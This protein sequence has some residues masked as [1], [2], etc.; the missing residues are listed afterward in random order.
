MYPA[1]QFLPGGWAWPAALM[2]VASALAMARGEDWP[3]FRGPTGQGISSEKGLPM[4]WSATENIAWKTAIPGEGW[5]SPISNKGRVFVTSAGE[6]GASCR[7]ICLDRADGKVL[8][9]KEVHRQKPLRKETRNS[10]ATSTPAADGKR[11]YA[12][13]ADGAILAADYEGRVEW[14]NRDVHFYGQHGLGTSPLLYG[15]LLIVSFDG[16][17]ETGDKTIGWQKPWDKSFLLALDRDSGKERWRVKRGLSR[18]AH[19]TPTILRVDGRDQ[20]IS[21]AGDVIQGFDPA[22]GRR[23]WSV[24][25]EGEGVVPS[26]VCGAGLVF[27]A[28]GFGSPAIRAVRPGDGAAKGPKTIWQEKRAVPMIPSML[29]AKPYLFTISQEGFAQCLIAATGELVWRE[30]V[31]GS[32]S[33]SPIWADGKLY[34]LADNGDTTILDAGPKFRVLGR[35]AIGERCQ[36][37]LAASA[38]QLFLRTEKHLF[39]IGV[40]DAN[41]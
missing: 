15:D 32:Y 29:Y 17:S 28:S 7:L 30:R 14:N 23:L 33:A 16:S 26:P 20:V 10:Y 22:S 11:I 19:T 12:V 8:W 5:S 41:R 6:G 38:G 25:S 24:R 39:C 13:F 37:S 27:T 21:N 2:I 31:G 4:R 34:L 9:D 36:A 1:R 18:I 40:K 3:A 35:N